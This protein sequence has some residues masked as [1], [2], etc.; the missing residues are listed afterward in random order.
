[1]GNLNALIFSSLIFSS[2]FAKIVAI[3]LLR[4]DNSYANCYLLDLYKSYIY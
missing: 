3:E 1:M 2:L 4:S